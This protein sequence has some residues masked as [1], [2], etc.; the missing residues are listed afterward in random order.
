MQNTCEHRDAVRR[1][2]KPIDEFLAE[3]GVAYAVVGSIAGISHGY[4]RPTADVDMVAELPA[5]DGLA[6][7]FEKRFIEKY[8]VDAAMIR[9]AFKWRAS[10]N[11]YHFETGMKIDVFVSKDSAF[12]REVT[13]RRELEK[14]D[15]DVAPAFWVESA[16]DLILSKLIWYRK[17]NEVS[18][19]KWKDVL[20]V[21][22]VQ[23]FSIDLDYLQNWAPQVGV[24]DLL[25]K[26][27]DEAGFNETG[28][29]TN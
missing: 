20:A 23:S 6:E 17:G 13:R 18:D 7:E 10:F 24:A 5:P 1:A 16:E 25:D 15:D 29:V 2:M 4:G 9:D 21:L 12:D 11:L 27:L 14:M 8:Y 22:K 26:A 28:N 3:K 19:Q